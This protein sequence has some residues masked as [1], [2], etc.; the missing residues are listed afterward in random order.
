MNNKYLYLHISTGFGIKYR[1]NDDNDGFPFHYL[2]TSTRPANFISKSS[3][4]MIT[5][6]VSICII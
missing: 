6:I 3:D 2:K 4:I 1:Y 5:M